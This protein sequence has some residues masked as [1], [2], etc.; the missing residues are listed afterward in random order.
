[1]TQATDASAAVTTCNNSVITPMSLESPS[2]SDLRTAAW[3]AWVGDDDVGDAS[4]KR[5][6][7]TVLTLGAK[8]VMH[9]EAR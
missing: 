6:P 2:H 1:M 4:F 3:L 9:R 5:H 8:V 7:L